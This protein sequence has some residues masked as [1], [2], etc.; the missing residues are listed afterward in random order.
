MK[1]FLLVLSLVTGVLFSCRNDQAPSIPTTINKLFGSRTQD[2][3]SVSLKNTDRSK[4]DQLISFRDASAKKLLYTD[5]LN[6]HERYL[7]WVEKLSGYIEKGGLS[8]EKK[9]LLIDLVANMEPEIF[10]DRDNAQKFLNGYLPPWKKKA[11]E[12][13]GLASINNLIG[14]LDVI[15]DQQIKAAARTSTDDSDGDD[16]F[17]PANPIGS[18][19]QKGKTCN[20]G[21]SDDRLRACG[22]TVGGGPNICYSNG[23]NRTWLGCGAVLLDDC[24][25]RCTYF[26]GR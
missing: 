12:V 17:D 26:I 9:Q 1:R 19:S 3:V 6:K 2:L 13:F 25:G 8:D 16:W 15:D 18:P 21:G 20:C 22:G 11:D 14:T 7:F 4:L 10:G 24:T 23:C 5:V